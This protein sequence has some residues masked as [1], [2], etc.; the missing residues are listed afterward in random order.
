M[1]A[2]ANASQGVVA[3]THAKEDR[4]WKWWIKF[5]SEYGLE[6]NPYLVGFDPE[7]IV[8]L[9]GSFTQAVRDCWFGQP[10]GGN[11]GI[12]SGTC[13][14]A[15]A[16]VA[17]AFTNAGLPD[18]RLNK[19]G[20]M[21]L[22]LQRQLKGM[23]NADPGTA[24]Q[25]ALSIGIICALCCRPTTCI[26]LL[27]FQDLILLAFFFA[28][29]SCEYLC[30]TGERRTKPLSMG[31]FM[32]IKDHRILPLDSPEE[33]LASADAVALTFAYQKND[34]R[35]ET[36]TQ[37]ATGHAYLCPVKVAARIVKRMQRWGLNETSYI[38]TYVGHSGVKFDLTSTDALKFLRDYVK[39]IDFTSLG[40]KSEKDIGLHSIRSSAA[41]AMYLN[42]VPVYTIMLLGRWSSDAFLRYIR[43]QVEQFS[44][45]VS[46]RM[47]STGQFHHVPT[48]RAARDPRA[49]TMRAQLTFA[50]TTGDQNLQFAHLPAFNVWAS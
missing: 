24:H 16:S 30:V 10:R 19:S 6:E 14:E 34:E 2:G 18:P 50:Q 31:S 20:K 33:L 26:T 49:R 13:S 23:K 43:K 27:V 11:E 7:F 17:K 21:A 4:H 47:I 29:R 3:S 15:V 40:L 46:A 8:R 38:Y 35:D 9:L 25:K 5:L 36:V 42:H 48:A 37:S 1:G 41:M 32:F 45:G 28:M 39:S 12:G 22:F 44:A